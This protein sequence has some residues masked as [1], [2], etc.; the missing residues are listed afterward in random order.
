MAMRLTLQHQFLHQGL[1]TLGQEKNIFRSH[2][3]K[4]A[5]ILDTI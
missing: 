4:M 3:F 2:N 1:V 5:Q